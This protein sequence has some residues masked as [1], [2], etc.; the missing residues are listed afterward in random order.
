[1]PIIPAEGLYQD[2]KKGVG[3]LIRPVGSALRA[4]KDRRRILESF[5]PVLASHPS[6][7]TS[8][9]DYFGWHEQDPE[10][11]QGDGTLI[12][13]TYGELFHLWLDPTRYVIYEAR[14]VRFLRRG[15]ETRRVF[16]WGPAALD[17]S[18][19]VGQWAFQRVLLRHE[20]LRF[21]P[22]VRTVIDLEDDLRKLGVSCHMCG[23]FDQRI[24]Y[25][26]KFPHDH[27]PSMVRTADPVLAQACSNVMNQFWKGAK[28]PAKWA[29]SK[30]LPQEIQR[31]VEQD[32]ERVLLT[33]E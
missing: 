33:G 15:G 27:D 14:L 17:D 12:S 13:A 32:V 28:A 22:R 11:T 18:S 26:F 25:F 31:Q 5:S 2:F 1:M 21:E 23:T 19:E 6:D 4:R 30:R 3:R 16:V 7:L 9:E 29:G 10:W 20:I 24:A 8:I